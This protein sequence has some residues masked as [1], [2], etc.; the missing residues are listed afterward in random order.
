MI[1]PSLVLAAHG[2]N[3]SP[4][5]NAHVQMLADRLSVT[6]RFAQVLP[7][8]HQGEPHFSQVL[9]QLPPGRVLVLPYMTSHGYYC[10]EVL[11]RELRKNARFDYSSVRILP[12]IGASAR[13][14]ELI[15]RRVQHLID[16]NNLQGKSVAILLVGHGTRRNAQSKATTYRIVDDLKTQYP[17]NEVR[18][19][20]IDDDPSLEHAV[21]ELPGS[22]L[23]AI[24]FFMG[25]GPHVVEEIPRQLG[26]AGYNGAEAVCERAGGRMVILDR[27]IGLDDGMLGVIE[28]MAEW[29]D[30]ANAIGNRRTVRLGTRS[31]KMALWQAHHV[32]DLLRD[33]CEVEIVE[34][35][36]CGDRDLSRPIEQLP[37]A[38]P[39]VDDVEFALTQGRIDLAVHALKDM[40]L[41]PT[42]GTV[43]AAVL[44][45]ADARE[46]LVTRDR[47]KLSQ[48]PSG[49]T[50]GTS[51][52]R[53]T[54][55]VLRLRPDVR[56][57]PL[58]GPVD[59]RIRQVYDGQM[60]AAILAVAGLERLGQLDAIDETFEYEAFLP[61]PGQAALVAQVRANDMFMR[62]LL[63]PLDDPVTRAVT[64]LE[65]D[66]QRAYESNSSV[67]VSA[68]AEC[69]EERFTL[70]A[71]L[72]HRDL[73]THQDATVI[74][75]EAD[76]VLT[77]MI[78]KLNAHL[79]I[80]DLEAVH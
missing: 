22:G 1:L 77:K 50:V 73:D 45:R 39:F 80:A 11:P 28:S 12:P 53:R 52:P 64:T 19:A 8:F 18:A 67:C 58:R 59:D 26:I 6:Q 24:P 51:S 72:S 25:S 55:Q 33:V 47:V 63:E 30:G 43:V 10:D 79:G 27:P 54:A 49:A 48:L 23:V 13:I 9:D 69:H 76:L 2:S 34:V 20:F 42:P 16:A 37:S 21:A 14:R 46:C 15:S 7:A 75:D 41:A 31:S 66:L 40:S 57:V 68:L 35:S 3:A 17:N 60:D 70:R 62:T 65:L 29:S 56:I 44:P 5:V 74:G 78:E 71:R 38:A 36:T 32:A 61:A 4:Q